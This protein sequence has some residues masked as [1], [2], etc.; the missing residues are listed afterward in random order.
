MVLTMA[1]LDE[2]LFPIEGLLDFSAAFTRRQ[3]VNSLN[4]IANV[5]EEDRKGR[6]ADICRALHGIPQLR[7]AIQEGTLAISATTQKGNFH[8]STGSSKRTITIITS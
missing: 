2:A 3:R 6:T 5:P 1:E 7:T 4:I 8:P